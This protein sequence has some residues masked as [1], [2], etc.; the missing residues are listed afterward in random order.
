[1]KNITLLLFIFLFSS[2]TF[3]QISVNPLKNTQWKGTV[4]VPDATGTIIT[5]DSVKVVFKEMMTG[6][7]IEELSYT[8]EG[9]IISMKKTAGSSP[10]TEA[11]V[12]KLSF[13]IFKDKMILKVISDD[14]TIRAV[15]FTDE[16][17]NPYGWSKESIQTK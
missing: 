1:M 7:P 11:Q 10:C 6:A 14:C 12:S 2:A 9:N 13:E 16:N 4:N 15:A 17:G 8:I 3:A 5:F